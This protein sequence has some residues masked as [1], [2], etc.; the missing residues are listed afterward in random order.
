MGGINH[1]PCRTYLYASTAMSRAFSRGRMCFEQANIALEDLILAELSGNTGS[2]EPILEALSEAGMH[3]DEMVVRIRELRLKMDEE[4]YVDLP[5]LSTIDLAALGRA[6]VDD[7]VLDNDMGWSV[8]QELTKEGGFAAVL[9]HFED[10]ALALSEELGELCSA[11][12]A[13]RPA[14]ASGDISSILEENRNGNFRSRFAAA[15]STWNAFMER[16]LA[17]S[18]LSTELWYRF[19][20]YG[21]LVSGPANIIT[22][23]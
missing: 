16:F 21:S 9:D 19:N 11:V 15:Y 2:V 1:Q 17:S 3:V 8:I 10:S 5:S 4:N 22:A 7:G 12:N 23:A 13:S 6:L 14:A 20:R 18:M